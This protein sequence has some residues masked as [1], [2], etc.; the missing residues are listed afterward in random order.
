MRAWAKS[1]LSVC[2]SHATMACSDRNLC[3]G[4]PAGIEGAV[5]AVERVWSRIDPPLP[6]RGPLTPPPPPPIQP[7]VT[8]EFGSPDP[9]EEEAAL[10][11]DASN[12]F[13]ELSRKAMLWTVRH[14]WADRARLAF[15]CYY[16]S[17]ILLLHHRNQDATVLLLREG[18]TQG[19]PLSMVVYGLTL[20][21]LAEIV[22]S[23]YTRGTLMTRA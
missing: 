3:A 18:V 20:V 12:G 22:P 15:N 4:L 7:P 17:A 1:C 8:Q 13:N 9:A 21:P 16:H 2:G 23:W 6:E 5:H 11:V 14:R 10:M 19:D